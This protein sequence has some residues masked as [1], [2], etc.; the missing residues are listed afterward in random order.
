M[1]DGRAKTH[2]RLVRVT[3]LVRER[4]VHLVIAAVGCVVRVLMVDRTAGSQRVAEHQ[5]GPYECTRSELRK[6][7]H[8]LPSEMRVGQTWIEFVELIDGT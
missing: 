6:R 5:D 4:G 2:H 3:T 7:A 8:Q 1:T